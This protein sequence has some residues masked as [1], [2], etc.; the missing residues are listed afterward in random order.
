MNYTIDASVF[1]ASARTQE[2]HHTANLDFLDQLQAQQ[3]NVF[4]PSLALPECSAA[5]ARRTGNT[6]LAQRL[7]SIVK[8]FIG[9]RLVTLSIPL[10]ERAAQIAAV[11]RLRGADSVYVAVAEEF[12][13]TLVTWDGEMLQRGATMVTTMTPDDWLKAQQTSSNQPK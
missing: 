7:V 8:N 11:R 12:A 1:I 6:A 3:P 5:L 4:C 10:A 9:M 13:A 2:P